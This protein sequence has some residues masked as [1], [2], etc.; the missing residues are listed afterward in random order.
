MTVTPTIFGALGYLLKLWLTMKTG[1]NYG[2][3]MTGMSQL[4]GNNHIPPTPQQLGTTPPNLPP[5]INNYHYNSP[6]KKKP[7]T[8]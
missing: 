1:G 6:K 5:V 7:D 4:G 2:A 3:A 8:S